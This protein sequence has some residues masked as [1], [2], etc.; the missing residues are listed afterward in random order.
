MMNLPEK[1]V[2]HFYRL[3]HSLLFNANKKFNIFKELRSP[4]DLHKSDLKN[5]GELKDKL[6][7][8]PQ[9]IDSFVKDNPM[10]L[11][12]EDLKIVA[13]WRNF[14]KGRFYIV[15]HLKNYTVF[16][17]PDEP[18]KA[19]GVLGLS[20]PLEEMIGSYLPVMVEAILLPFENKIV[21]DGTMLPYN[22]IFGSNMRRSINDRY[23]QAKTTFGIITTLPLS[24]E[25]VKPSDS[26]ILKSYLKTEYSRDIHHEEI[27]ELVNKNPD[28]ATVY[29]EEMGKVDAR[30][31]RKRLKTIG[32]VEG[33]FALIDG[34]IIASGR[35]REEVER[36][37]KFMLP[38]E[39]MR[40]AYVFQLKAK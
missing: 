11:S 12:S 27:Q 38:A 32:V 9:L 8:V 31:H 24:P 25:K 21:Y 33:W 28:L 23:K 3:Y 6:Y 26:E 15:R 5:L 20:T 40:L 30:A 7:E 13:D 14:I 29:Y 37:L 34:I 2:K 39:K 36:I 10:D 4:E 16:L 17:D 35:T 22:V 1:D 19:Y 18:P